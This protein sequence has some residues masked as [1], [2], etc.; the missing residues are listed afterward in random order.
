MPL[1]RLA[2]LTLYPCDIALFRFPSITL[3]RCFTSVLSQ[4]LGIVTFRRLA[5]S[6]SRCF[7]VA[8]A[9]H[10]CIA[11]A[12]HRRVSMSQHYD[13][14]VSQRHNFKRFHHYDVTPSW[15]CAVEPPHHCNCAPLRCCDVV[16]RRRFMDIQA[17]AREFCTE[18]L[19]TC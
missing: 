12:E 9:H 6:V 15:H 16:T 1:N 19:G 8:D 17:I 2:I 14:G 4:W 13:G 7:S 11:M 3:L 18:C 10:R 5:F